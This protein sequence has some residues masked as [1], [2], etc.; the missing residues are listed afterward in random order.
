MKRIPVNATQVTTVDETLDGKAAKDFSGVIVRL[1]P[2]AQV[3]EDELRTLKAELAK[4]V[5]ALKVLP[6]PA[7]DKLVL[8]SG[9]LPALPSNTRAFLLELATKSSSKR[10]PELLQYLEEL[11]DAEGI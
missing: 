7:S 5:L 3:G 10:L 9:Q 2:T 11:A 6:R 8:P 1:R 4:H